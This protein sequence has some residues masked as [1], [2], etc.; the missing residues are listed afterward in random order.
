MTEI[1]NIIM[2]NPLAQ[3][4][5][6]LAMFVSFIWLMQKDDRNTM[7]IIIISCILWIIHFYL[8]WIYSAMATDAIWLIR[9]ALSLKFKRSK[10]AFSWIIISLILMW[11]LTYESELSLLPIIGSTI[12]AYWYFFLEWFRLR[13][14]IFV[15]SFLRLTFWLKTGSVSAVLNEIVAQLILIFVIY[16]LIREEYGELN[17]FEK[18]STTFRKKFLPDAN[19]F[20]FIYDYIRFLKTSFHK[21]IKSA[22]DY[23]NIL[24]WCKKIR[25]TKYKLQSVPEEIKS[26]IHFKK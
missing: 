22:F 18:I 15:S 4:F 10:L 19:R 21:R 26:H 9:V 23:I 14:L 12:S 8:M 5:W 11:F 24:N 3:T 17:I 1:V 25:F 13:M 20:L 16:K 6:F 2:E 7:K